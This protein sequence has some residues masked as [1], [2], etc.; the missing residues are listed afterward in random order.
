MR[1]CLFLCICICCFALSGC[2]YKSKETVAETAP[3]KQVESKSNLDTVHREHYLEMANKLNDVLRN[4]LTK[5]DIGFVDLYFVLDDLSKIIY[6]IENPES[7]LDSAV[8]KYASELKKTH[9]TFKE[10]VDHLYSQDYAISSVNARNMDAGEL[11]SFDEISIKSAVN[12][13]DNYISE[14][15]LIELK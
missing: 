9:E 10:V 11:D 1:R 12:T 14:L 7:T 6:L 5:T 4:D 8:T 15:L 13:L 2:T 3:I